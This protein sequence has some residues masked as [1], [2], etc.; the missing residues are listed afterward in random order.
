MGETKRKTKKRKRKP[1]WEHDEA[2]RSHL[3][4]ER[5]KVEN[6]RKINTGLKLTQ[7]QHKT[8]DRKQLQ[9]DTREQEKK[10][11]TNTQQRSKGDKQGRTN[12]KNSE[13]ENKR[14]CKVL[15][16]LETGSKVKKWL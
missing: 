6:R 16:K 5:E 15:K 14:K 7:R 13:K 1:T 8:T 11:Q 2:K 10:K 12:K 3:K 9:I 4:A